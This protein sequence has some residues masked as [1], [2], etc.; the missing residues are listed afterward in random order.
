MLTCG[1]NT[2]EL[3]AVN[4][5]LTAQKNGE[6]EHSA[7][8]MLLRGDFL[9]RLRQKVVQANTNAVKPGEGAAYGCPK[10][11]LVRYMEPGNWLWH[12]LRDRGRDRPN[13]MRL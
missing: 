3:L 12:R 8:E 11:K 7:V 5:Q 9:S 2:E 13:K 6:V 10:F 1:V 4:K